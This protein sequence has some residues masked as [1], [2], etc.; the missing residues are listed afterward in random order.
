MFE[1]P[2]VFAREQRID[3]KWRNFVERNLQPIRAREPAVNLA[4]DIE[5][6]VALRHL[7]DLFHVE[8]L[9]PRAEEEQ[10][11]ESEPRAE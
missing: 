7:A 8:G 5:D 1:E 3:E 6:S 10:N 2:R 4:V 9:R 11:A